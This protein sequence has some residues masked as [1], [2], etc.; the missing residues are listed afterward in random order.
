MTK[1][2]ELEIDRE[3]LNEIKHF[4]VMAHNINNKGAFVS[5]TNDEKLELIKDR[6]HDI[7]LKIKGEDEQNDKK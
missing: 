2:N 7:L 4:L 1:S 6:A 3:L 5:F